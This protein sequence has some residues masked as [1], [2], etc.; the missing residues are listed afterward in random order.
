[1]RNG[2]FF[3]RRVFFLLTGVLCIC[4]GSFAQT[5]R[6]IGAWP[7]SV[8]NKIE[9]FLNS[10]LTLQQRKVAVFDCDGT[11]FGQAPHYL[12]DEALYSYAKQWGVKTNKS[13]PSP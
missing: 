5:F 1:M 2:L 13:N 6:P 10:T 3:F 8:N 11:L 12:A 7:D 4:T 9:N